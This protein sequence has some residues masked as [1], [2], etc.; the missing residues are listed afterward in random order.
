M[1]GGGCHLCQGEKEV[2]P[3]SAREQGSK[4]G[5]V[6]GWS[7]NVTILLWIWCMHVRAIFFAFHA[8]LEVRVNWLRD[9][10]GGVLAKAKGD[11]LNGESL[12]EV[13][14]GSCRPRCQIRQRRHVR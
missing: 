11:L 8:V 12:C 3:H 1:R 6:F 2:H 14:S 9:V 4:R 5:D 10:L 13:Q 7:Q